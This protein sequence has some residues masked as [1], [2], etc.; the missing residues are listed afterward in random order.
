MREKPVSEGSSLFIQIF[1]LGDEVEFGDIDSGGTDHIAEMASNAEVDPAINRRFVR[2]PEA[3]RSWA[4]LL[5]A[6]E[7]GR[8]ARDRTDSHAG[9]TSRADIQVS[10]R[11]GGFLFH[12]KLE[13][14]AHSPRE[15]RGSFEALVSDFLHVFNASLA[16]M[17]PV[18]ISMPSRDFSLIRW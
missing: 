3:I 12:K 13:F 17:Y 11:P 5:R 18:L 6:G 16:A 10:F 9:R 1:G 7:E 2:F 14:T 4:C 15:A 8:D